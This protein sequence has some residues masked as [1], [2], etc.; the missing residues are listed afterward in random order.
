V[1][2]IASADRDDVARARLLLRDR[3]AWRR[4]QWVDDVAIERLIDHVDND[5]QLA[6]RAVAVEL[7]AEALAMRPWPS[8]M[9]RVL[10][11]GHPG[12]QGLVAELE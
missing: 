10:F 12:P 1:K 3:Q 5:L 11:A 7:A 6:S 8:W 4:N 2:A 9:H